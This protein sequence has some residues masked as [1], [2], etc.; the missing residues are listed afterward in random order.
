MATP[1]AYYDIYNSIYHIAVN[2]TIRLYHI[3]LAGARTANCILLCY[4][5]NRLT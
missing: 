3:L 2:Q 4:I 1:T 5:T